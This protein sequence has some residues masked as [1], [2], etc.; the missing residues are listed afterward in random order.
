MIWGL[1]TEQVTLAEA[2][3]IAR[4]VLA[5]QWS[6]DACAYE[7]RREIAN[8]L[9]AAAQVARHRGAVGRWR[10]WEFDDLARQVRGYCP[11]T[12]EALAETHDAVL[13]RMT[14]WGSIGLDAFA[15]GA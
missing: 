2:L 12:P 8:V 4:L 10:D 9:E 11:Q 5:R 6:A 13:D 7:E 1:S 14:G 15:P 3:Q